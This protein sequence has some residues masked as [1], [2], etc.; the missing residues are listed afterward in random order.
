MAKQVF[1]TQW[2]HIDYLRVRDAKNGRVRRINS[3]YLIEAEA[4]RVRNG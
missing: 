3:R 4:E 1:K 2:D